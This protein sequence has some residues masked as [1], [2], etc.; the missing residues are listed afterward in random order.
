MKKQTFFTKKLFQLI[1]PMFILAFS[2][3]VSSCSGDDS[4]SSG[5]KVT[6]TNSS[7]QTLQ[8]FTVVFTNSRDEIITTENKG[9]LKPGEKVTVES[10]IGATEYFMMGA[11]SGKV[12]AS[13]NYE[14]SV[15]KQVI[16][17]QTLE[18]WMN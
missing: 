15:T 5:K 10:P 2:C 18:F 6:I 12:K 16:T 8:S 13:P 9:T 3:C 14:V 4:P 17:D 7:S 1:I 11:V